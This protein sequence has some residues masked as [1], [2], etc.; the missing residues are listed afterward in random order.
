MVKKCGK[1]GYAT[2]MTQHYD[3][4]MKNIYIR[5]N[6][7]WIKFGYI[8]PYCSR[9]EIFK[10]KKYHGVK[11]RLYVRVN[12]I[13]KGFAWYWFGKEVRFDKKYILK[14]TRYDTKRIHK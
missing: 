1:C 8:C 7:K 3:Y 14:T 12:G 9:Y 13:F 2:S 11:R 4:S 5:V 6:Q 10:I